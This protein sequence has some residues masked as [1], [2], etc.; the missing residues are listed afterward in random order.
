M[1]NAGQNAIAAQFKPREVQVFL[2]EF[3]YK[4]IVDALLHAG[5][6]RCYNRLCE[7]ALRGSPV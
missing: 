6:R 4:S 5:Y 1:N 3:H 7:V 2:R